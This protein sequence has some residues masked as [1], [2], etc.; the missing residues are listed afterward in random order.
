MPTIFPFS[1]RK[2]SIAGLAVL[3][4]AAGSSAQAATNLV[5][6][7][8]FEVSSPI[9]TS[10]Y[11]TSVGG[12]GQIGNIVNLPSWTKTPVLSDGSDGFA[13]VINDQADNRLAPI[14]TNPYPSQGGG[15]PSKFTP[16][17]STNIFLWGPDYQPAPVNNGF[18]G[19]GSGVKFV[20]I[21]G[22]YGASILS[23]TITTFDTTKQY[24]LSFQYAGAQ[25]SGERGATQQQ[26][27]VNLGGVD[28][29]TPLWI[30]ADQGFTPWQTYTSSP[31]TPTSATA[32]L[33]F[34][35]WGRA[36]TGTSSLP[37]FLLLDNVQ[38]LENTPNPPIP[39]VPGPSTA[40]GPLPLLGAGMAFSLSRRL[41]QRIKGLA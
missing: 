23:Q 16:S 41:R 37:P 15:F 39:P 4:L 26:W 25:E 10:N 7:G 18:T 32:T 12:I 36:A 17:A 8:D 27:K 1:L 24:V 11:P 5:Q 6:N 19:S 30:N 13:F 22:D 34:E 3:A 29:S 35:A 14:G 38:I 28:Y 31:F 21:D 33:S 9:N 2:P 40:P 20:G